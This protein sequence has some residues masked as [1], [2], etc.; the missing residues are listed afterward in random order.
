MIPLMYEPWEFRETDIDLS[1]CSEKGIIVFGTD[2]KDERL[3]TIE[4]IGYIILSLLLRNNMV[5]V[6]PI[7]IL[8]LGCPE[9]VEP[10]NKILNSSGYKVDTVTNYEKITEVSE[11]DSIIVLEHRDDRVVISSNRDSY[12]KSEDVAA[13]AL[14]G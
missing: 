8:L 9:F 13:N 5:P 7:K 6:R 11:Y 12:I 4:Y 14:P 2:E 3:K 10:T 1:I